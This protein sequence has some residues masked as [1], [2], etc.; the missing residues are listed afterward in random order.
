MRIASAFGLSLSLS[1]GAR[2]DLGAP[3]ASDAQPGAPVRLDAGVANEA[4]VC[5]QSPIP[6]YG[7]S[8]LPR[9][10]GA[11]QGAPL[12]AGDYGADASYP[13]ACT[14]TVPSC[15]P[16]SGPSVVCTCSVLEMVSFWACDP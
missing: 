2:T 15:G 10:A 16:D 13:L 12:A 6:I 8:P 4:S 3:E 1:C 14:L 5:E 11:C 7:C 9:N